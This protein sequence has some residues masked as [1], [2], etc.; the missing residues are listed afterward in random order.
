VR[1]FFLSR[2]LIEGRLFGY[3]EVRSSTGQEGWLGGTVP[4]GRWWPLFLPLDEIGD[5]PVT[6]AGKFLLRFP[7]NI[8]LSVP[9]GGQQR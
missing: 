9:S 4:G 5:M 3:S 7:W 2:R 1:A 8:G 6:A